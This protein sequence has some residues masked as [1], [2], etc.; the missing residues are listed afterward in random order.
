[1]DASGRAILLRVELLLHLLAVPV[2]SLLSSRERKGPGAPLPRRPGQRR[3]W[4]PVDIP[5]WPPYGSPLD[6][7]LPL[8]DTFIMNHDE[9]L[10]NSL[11]VPYKETLDNFLL[12]AG[13]SLR[14]ER[15][16][17]THWRGREA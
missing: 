12:M 6:L 7:S 16:V 1:M 8:S 9:I 17:V 5:V 3:C 13:A 4:R 11:G 2:P 15:V 14:R 10:G